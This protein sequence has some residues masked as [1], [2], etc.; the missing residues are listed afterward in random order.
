[1]CGVRARSPQDLTERSAQIHDAFYAELG[2][3]LDEVAARGPFV[4]YDV[5]SYNHRR[6]GVDAGPRAR[7]R[8]TPRSTSAPGR[9]TGERWGGVVDAFIG[10]FAGR[11]TAGGEI[12]VRE[13]VRFEGAH[14]AQWVHERYPDHGVALALEFKKTYMDEW[15]GEPDQQ[16]IDTLAR[17]LGQTVEPVLR[18]LRGAGQ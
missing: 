12:D 15:T 9:S 5:H 6:D 17:A 7:S 11:D 16:R 8:T 4:L 2:A 10:A 3:R 1:M 13:N 14:L 18:A